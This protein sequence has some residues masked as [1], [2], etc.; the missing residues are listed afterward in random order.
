MNTTAPALPGIALLRYAVGGGPRARPTSAY[1]VDLELRHGIRL[2]GTG[3]RLDGLTKGAADRVVPPHQP[4]RRDTE[5][6]DMRIA[7]VETKVTA[8]GITDVRAVG[9]TAPAPARPSATRRAQAALFRRCATTGPVLRPRSLAVPAAA[10]TA[11]Q[12]SR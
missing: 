7:V 8:A 11:G 1:A 2:L 6:A 5:E 10:L 4:E 3:Q 9:V 12:T